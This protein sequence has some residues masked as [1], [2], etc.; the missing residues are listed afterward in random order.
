[1][2]I[3]FVSIICLAIALLPHIV[4][5]LAK[6]ASWL[7]GFKLAYKPFGI[8]AL[9]LTIIFL[10]LFAYGYYY[11][12]YR[13]ELKQY[14]FQ[15]P[16]IPQSFNDYRIVQIS[17]IHSGGW[18]N[19][20]E[21]LEAIVE[22]INSLCPDLIC[23]T[24]DL[25]DLHPAETQYVTETLSK[26][27]A[28]DGV[29]AIMGNHDY[30]PYARFGGNAERQRAIEQLQ[31]TERERLKWNLL[32]NSNTII[33]H[34]GDS[35]A[36]IGTENQ[37]MGAHS[38]IRRG[39]LGKAMS[40]TEGMMRILLTH[41][42]THWRGEVLRHTDIPLTLSGH[43][44]AMQF[45]VLGWTPS[46]YIYPECD[47]WYEENNQKLYVNIGIGGSMPMRIGA[48]PEITMFTLKSGK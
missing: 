29:I 41:D 5:M 1:M 6:M 4:Y 44:H 46:K 24:G 34:G 10:S 8:T 37:S 30:M 12:R 16:C 23:F 32:L 18:S 28:R 15:H 20:K 26:L 19:G 14:I 38:V 45:R 35:I 40:G 21:T 48:T 2:R 3:I 13:Y 7:V 47:G 36:I 31:K 11:G 33:S 27:R 9:I 43:T 42:P 17:D 39:D 25:V 22:Q